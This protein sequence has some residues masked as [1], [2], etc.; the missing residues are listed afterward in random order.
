MNTIPATIT[1]QAA[2]RYNLGIFSGGGGGGAVATAAGGAG[3]SGA[4]V[5]S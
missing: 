1:T 5:M 2:A 4:S 3:G